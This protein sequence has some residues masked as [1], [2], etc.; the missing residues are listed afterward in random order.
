LRILS[1]PIVNGLEADLMSA[2]YAS[3]IVPLDGSALAETAIPFAIALARRAGIGA[4]VELVHVHDPGSFAPNAPQ[5]D[6]GLEDAKAVRMRDE[7]RALAGRLA[8]ESGTDISAKLLRGETAASL[9]AHAAERAADL[10][11]TTSHGRSGFSHAWFG[12]VTEQ[13]MHSSRTP[14][15]VVRAREDAATARVTEPL[16]QHVLVPID[17]ETAGSE[18]LRLA[19]AMGAGR[20]TI[21]TLLT[22]VPLLPL[23]LTPWVGESAYIGVGDLQGRSANASA[24][25]ERI[26]APAREA[27]ARVD[28]RVVPQDRTASTILNMVKESGADLIVIVAQ[29]SGAS[30]RALVGSVADKV[31]R[32]STVPLLVLHRI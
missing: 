15:L 8:S 9:L 19:L 32:G 17:I 2:H 16:F 30:E 10:I 24:L 29:S 14:V 26:A 5:L 20:A 28:V 21:F 4:K 18:A 13:I 12:S 27:G 23:V 6:T 31:M 3:I 22:V 1:I 7:M 11:V 25:L